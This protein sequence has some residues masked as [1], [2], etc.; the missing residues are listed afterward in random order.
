MPK[1]TVSPST[2]I[3]IPQ[4]LGMTDHARCIRDSRAGENTT[5][6]TSFRPSGGIPKALASQSVALCPRTL[7]VQAR[8][9][10]F[11]SPFGMT[12]SRGASELQCDRETTSPLHG[13]S[14]QS[15]NNQYPPRVIPSGARNPYRPGLLER[16]SMP[17]PLP[18]RPLSARAW[19]QGFL[20]RYSEQALGFLGMMP[21][22]VA[23]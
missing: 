10:G 19:P 7:S 4:S 11:L 3:G 8:S 5:T 20:Q 22:S 12:P 14:D 17:K 9:Q 15:A 16:F 1:N 21:K 13:H 2:V 6:P 18:Q 23:F